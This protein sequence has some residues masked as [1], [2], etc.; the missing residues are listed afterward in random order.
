MDDNGDDAQA[1]AF[2]TKPCIGMT[3]VHLNYYKLPDYE[4]LL[5]PQQ[6]ELHDCRKKKIGVNGGKV[7][8]K[9]PNANT[10]FNNRTKK[11]I[12]YDVNK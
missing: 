1:S 7:K 4:K 11:A 3:G 9:K 8:A 12:S 10:R 6:D 5:K 2:D